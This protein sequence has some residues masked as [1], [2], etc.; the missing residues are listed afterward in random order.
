MKVNLRSNRIGNASAVSIFRSLEHNTSLEELDL[1]ENS[2]LADGDNEAVGC[3][4][5]RMLNVNRKLRLLTV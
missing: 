2:Q 5:E 4:I 3:A 1:M